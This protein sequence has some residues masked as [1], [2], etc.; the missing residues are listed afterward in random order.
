MQTTNLASYYALII[1]RHGITN[2]EL[3]YSFIFFHALV[4]ILG[5][6]LKVLVQTSEK[7]IS[8]MH[9]ALFH[10]SVLERYL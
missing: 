7:K 3:F 6:F 8:K 9:K 10:I 4:T 2:M 1:I 5:S